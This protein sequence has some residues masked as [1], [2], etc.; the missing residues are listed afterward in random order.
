MAVDVFE[1]DVSPLAIQG[2][3]ADELAA[4]V[5]GEETRSIRFFRYK[6]LSF[7]GTDLV[8][9]R[10][11]YSKQGGFEIYVEVSRMASRCGMRCSRRAGIST[12][13]RAAPT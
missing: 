6:R 4:R 11:G 3:Q 1:P 2:P 8:V 7:N 10:S 5:F 12:C 13:G 9:A